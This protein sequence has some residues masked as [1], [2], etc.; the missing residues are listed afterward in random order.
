MSFAQKTAIITGAT[1]GIGLSIAETF[2]K[3]GAR[4]ILIGRDSGRVQLVQERFR[5]KFGDQEHVGIVL[6]VSNKQDIDSVLKVKT[7]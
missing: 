2:A 4:T 3:Q 7:R 1:R 6:D 5:E